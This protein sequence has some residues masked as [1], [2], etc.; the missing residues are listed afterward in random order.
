M[1][2]MQYL[3]LTLIV[4]KNEEDKFASSTD[5]DE[6]AHNEAYPDF[7]VHLLCVDYPV[8]ALD[9]EVQPLVNHYEAL[10]LCCIC[11]YGFPLLT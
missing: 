5:P 2:L 6:V 9:V 11:T 3:S 4:P 1:Y 10:P 8:I 7:T